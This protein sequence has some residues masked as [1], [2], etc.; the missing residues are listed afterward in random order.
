M[1]RSISTMSMDGGCLCFNFI[2]TVHSRKDDVIYDYL[3]SYEDLLGWCKRIEILPEQR[4]RQINALARGDGKMAAKTLTKARELR[5][6]MYIVFSQIRSEKSMPVEPL[7][8]FNRALT[9]ALA[10]LQLHIAKGKLSLRWPLA[11]SL[12]EPLW[13]IL[14][15]SFDVWTQ[16]DPLRIKECPNCGWIFLDKTKNKGRRWCNMKACGS[17]DKALRYY[18][19]NKEKS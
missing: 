3:N 7:E 18:Y 19:R 9:N 6:A 4:L 15:S 16:E 17:N 12:E 5:E 1:E 13:H 8:K 2:N 14:K 10:Q 11:V